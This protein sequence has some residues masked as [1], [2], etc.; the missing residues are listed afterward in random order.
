MP[1]QD[2]AADGAG[3]GAENA[4]IESAVRDGP[5][6]AMQMQKRRALPVAAWKRVPMLEI[7]RR[8]R[9]GAEEYNV[10]AAGYVVLYF[11]IILR[12]LFI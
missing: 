9:M 3:A 4:R 7:L 11:S 2:N 8:A 10:L 6:S 1:G 5:A 12:A